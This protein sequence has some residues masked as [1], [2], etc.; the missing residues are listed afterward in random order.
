MALAVLVTLSAAAVHRAAAVASTQS[1]T[2]ARSPSFEQFVGLRGRNYAP[3]SEEYVERA[4]LYAAAAEAVDGHNENPHRSWTANVGKFADYTAEERRRL[5]GLVH[6]TSAAEGGGAS[7]QA[8]VNLAAHKAK[9]PTS[10]SWSHLKSMQTVKNQGHCGSCWAASALKA[11]EAHYEIAKN[12]TRTFSIQHLVSCAKNERHCGGTGGCHGATS[13]IAFQYILEH[14]VTT[15]EQYPYTERDAECPAPMESAALRAS[16]L[17]MLSWERMPENQYEPIMRALVESGP[18][19]VS[20]AASSGFGDFGIEMYEKGIYDYCKQDAILNH[21]MVLYG[22]GQESFKDKGYWTL[23]NSWGEDWGEDGSIRVLRRLEGEE[24][25]CGTDTDPRKGSGC[26]GG[27][28]TIRVCGSC[29]ILYKGTFPRLSRDGAAVAKASPAAF[30][31]PAAAAAAPEPAA[32][33]ARRRKRLWH[34]LR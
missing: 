28:D 12:E 27:P 19:V 22:Y 5:H 18:M 15:D 20:V 6:D 10:F 34:R 30:L 14:G 9:F 3:G 11:L 1:R 24:F 8:T 16:D 13:D 21:A 17:G 2:V 33:P 7:S 23:M 29:G 26:P 25:Y 4:R 32:E 31:E